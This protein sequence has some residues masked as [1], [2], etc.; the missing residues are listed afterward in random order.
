MTGTFITP[1]GKMRIG[2]KRRFILIRDHN[3]GPF[4]V[5][6]SDD[7]ATLTKIALSSDYILDTVLD[8]A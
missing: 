3:R 1:F 4:I 2:S 6:R 5:K 8:T 7:R